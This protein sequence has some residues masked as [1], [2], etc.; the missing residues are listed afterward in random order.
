MRRIGLAIMIDVSPLAQLATEAQQSG[1]PARILKPV[2]LSLSYSPS[3]IWVE[4]VLGLNLKERS[5]HGPED[6]RP[7]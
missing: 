1:T 4:E 2:K 7:A 5:R 6:R 3:R